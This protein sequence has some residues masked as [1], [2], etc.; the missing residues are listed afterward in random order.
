[1]EGSSEFC[2]ITAAR[3]VN[4]LRQLIGAVCNRHA[5]YLY[6]MTLKR[7]NTNDEIIMQTPL[8]LKH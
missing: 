3:I 4:M 8:K 1:M 2:Y 6:N 5:P 7:Q